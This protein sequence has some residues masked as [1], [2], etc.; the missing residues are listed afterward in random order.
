MTPRQLTER[1]MDYL[2]TGDDSIADEIISTSMRV[3]TIQLCK[4]D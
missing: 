2:N 3:K 4:A 1:L